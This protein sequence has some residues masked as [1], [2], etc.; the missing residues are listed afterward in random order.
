MKTQ[1]L[2]EKFTDDEEKIITNLNYLNQQVLSNLCETR[3]RAQH[4]VKDTKKID[5]IIS[6][7]MKILQQIRHG[8]IIKRSKFFDIVCALLL[9]IAIVILYWE[10]LRLSFTYLLRFGIILVF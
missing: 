5:H 4:N 8:S 9:I 2:S 7:N 10:N 1:R 6:E 3:N